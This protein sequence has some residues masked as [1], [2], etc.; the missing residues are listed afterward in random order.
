AT[1][2]AAEAVWVGARTQK[3]PAACAAGFQGTMAAGESGQPVVFTQALRAALVALAA[4]PLACSV[5]DSIWP[6][7]IWPMASLVCSELAKASWPAL[8][9]RS[10][11]SRAICTP[12][13]HR[14]L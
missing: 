10:T 4:A 2:S 3:N 11:F 12:F 14:V 9:L 1:N 8:T 7:A 13:G 5:A 6:L